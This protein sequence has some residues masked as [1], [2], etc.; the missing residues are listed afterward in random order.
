M[1]QVSNPIAPGG[2]E[3][4]ADQAPLI[5][6]VVPVYNHQD[7]VAE[8]LSSLLAQ[9]YPHL[10]LIAVN[11]GS[12]DQSLEVLKAYR[13]RCERRFARFLLIDQ[14]NAGVATTLNRGIEAARG[15]LVYLIASDDLATPDAIASLASALGADFD[16]CLTNTDETDLLLERRELLRDADRPGIERRLDGPRTR[17]H[18]RDLRLESMLGRCETAAAFEDRGVSLIELGGLRLEEAKCL[19]FGKGGPLGPQSI[20]R[21]IEILKL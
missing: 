11:D 21:K 4:S 6:I 15:A 10:E 20:S 2:R 14:E 9:T 8:T 16:L 12:T 5:S 19:P 18:R 7:Y 1:A 3:D 13:D 17:G